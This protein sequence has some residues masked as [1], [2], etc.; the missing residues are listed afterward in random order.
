MQE[1]L[2]DV[3]QPLKQRCVRAGSQESLEILFNT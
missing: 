2:E 1:V 3:V